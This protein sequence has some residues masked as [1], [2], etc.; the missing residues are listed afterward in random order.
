MA[1]IGRA[2]VVSTNE[3]VEAGP[4]DWSRVDHEVSEAME[5]LPESASGMTT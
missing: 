3:P 5:R 2:R 4:V 1:S